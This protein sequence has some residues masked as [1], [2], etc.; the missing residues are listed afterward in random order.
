[1]QQYIIR[2]SLLNVFVLFLVA[3]MVFGA[4][5]IDSGTVV[6]NRAQ[7]CYQDVG[8]DIEACRKSAKSDLG[9]TD[10]IPKQY[11]NFMTDTVQ[12]NLGESFYTKKSVLDDIR[13]RAIPSIELGLLQLVV[14]LSIALPIGIISAIRQDTWIDYILRFVCGGLARS[15]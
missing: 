7:G 14:A 3:T 11:W 10:S 5:R 8:G 6:G 15:A 13:Q 9:L 4:L 2:R 12:L 1:M